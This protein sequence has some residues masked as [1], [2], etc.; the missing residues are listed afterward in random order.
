MAL[1]LCFTSSASVDAQSPSANKVAPSQTKVAPVQVAPPQTKVA[2]VQVAPSQTKVVLSAPIQ[3]IIGELLPR[4]GEPV[5]L[6]KKERGLM[7]QVVVAV[8]KKN[9]SAADGPWKALVESQY[10][11]RG[12]ATDVDALV[13]FVLRGAYLETSGDLKRRTEKVSAY[14]EVKRQLREQLS[15]LRQK[16]AE[17]EN[18]SH[19]VLVR[20][21]TLA[22]GGETTRLVQGQSVVMTR[23]QLIEY[24]KTVEEMLS[25]T[26][27]DAQLANLD[28]QDALQKQQ[29]TLQM[30]SNILKNQ[31]DTAKHIIQKLGG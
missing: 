29:Q 5:N 27:D 22:T 21:V 28:L 25:S 4:L 15:E 19:T 14:N 6:T 3:G 11:R 1:L 31:H 7:N 17:L 26:G 16:L 13:Q 24:I 8:R 2:P 30:M 12:D 18:E 20:V 9:P 23:A 10:K